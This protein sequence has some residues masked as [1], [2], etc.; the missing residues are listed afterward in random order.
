[1][2]LN[3]R[4]LE[5]DVKRAGVIAFILGG[6]TLFAACRADA[7]ARAIA[8][9][10]EVSVNQPVTLALT[11]SFTATDTFLW[12][13][14]AGK[15]EGA[16]DRPAV[17]YVA[18]SAGN[19][20]VVVTVKGADGRTEV[21]STTIA[22]TNQTAPATEQAVRTG[23]AGAP[24]DVTSVFVPSG[25]MGD[26]E[27]RGAVTFEID[28]GR[29]H[30]PPT[31]IRIGYRPGPVGWAAVAWQFPENNWGTRPGRDLRSG[32]YQRVSVWA[33]GVA[34]RRGNFPRVQFKAGG[35]TSPANPYKAS[36]EVEGDFVT[37]T[38]EWKQYS[39]DLSGRDLSSVIA[40]F[41][42][43][44]RGQDV[45]DGATFFLDDIEYR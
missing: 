39:L 18:T 14:N 17:T 22:V 4:L 42:V 2:T 5:V 35:A 16:T 27:T 34:D 21:T 32:N 40:A 30:S 43:V 1:V 3:L 45:D 24:F 33:R 11:G 31:A 23:A 25:F 29:P 15:F 19:A 36:F 6:L 41:I 12:A 20:T 28:R 26:G 10:A 7:V 8:A 38:G 44:I 9:P 37:L 13:A